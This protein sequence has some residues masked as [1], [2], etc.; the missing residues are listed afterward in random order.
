M[1]Y[2]T[3]TRLLVTAGAAAIVAVAAVH[4]DGQAAQK[5]APAKAPATAK[6]AIPRLADGHPDLQG[7]YDLAT[8]TP[9]ERAAGT[10]LVMTDEQAAKLEQANAARK[11]TGDA[12]LDGNRAA[13][14]VGGDGSAGPAG[15]VGGYNSFWIDA[16]SHFSVVEG[17]RRGSIVIDPPEGRVPALT[18]AASAPAIAVNRVRIK[19]PYSPGSSFDGSG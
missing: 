12:P 2:E 15:N 6:R 14:P 18:A 19:T 9:V 8:L 17:Q 7:M 13:P 10:P 4:V 1:K 11:V 3:R 5:A 16:G